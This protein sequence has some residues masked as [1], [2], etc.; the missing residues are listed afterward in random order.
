MTEQL[1]NSIIKKLKSR[2]YRPTKLSKLAREM[3]IGTEDY[4]LF[5]TAYDELVKSG[6]VVMGHGNLIQLR[7]LSD[8][9][10]GTFRSNPRGFGF[11]SPLEPDLHEDLFIPPEQSLDALTGDVVEAKVISRQKKGGKIL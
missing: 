10:V 7:P 5:K 11:V 8:H 1:K 3:E 4:S 9:V 6:K 2:D